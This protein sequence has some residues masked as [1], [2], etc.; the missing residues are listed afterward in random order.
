MKYKILTASIPLAVVLSSGIAQEANA[1]VEPFIGEIMW[2]GYPF[3]PRGWANADG[4]LLP[5]AQNTALFSLYGSTYGGDGRTTFALPDL[6]G[7]VSIHTGQGPGLSNYRL[8]AEGGQE[9]VTLTV[10]ELPAHNHSINAS[11]DAAYKNAAGSIPG[12]GKAKIYDTPA[13]ADTAFDASTVGMTG[14]G[15]AHENRA[16]YATLRACVALQGIYPSRN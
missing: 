16:P 10:N 8:G 3:C 15:T 7:R 1:E 13:N 12:S 9:G 5:I 11:S 2:V 6:R 4:Q 14:N